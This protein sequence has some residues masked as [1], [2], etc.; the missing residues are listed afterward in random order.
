VVEYQP[1]WLTDELNKLL[2]QVGGGPYH[3]R[4]RDTILRLAEGRVIGRTDDDTWKLPETCTRKTWEGR[5]YRDA[6]GN[7]YKKPGWRDEPAVQAA[8]KAAT[9]R[10]N[11]W[12]DQA[13]ARRIA[14]RLEKLAEARDLLAEYSPLAV[15][16]LFVLMGQAGNEETRRKAAN[17][18]LD[19]ADEG[20]ATKS[21]VQETG[22]HEQRLSFNLRDFSTEFLESLLRPEG[23]SEE[24]PGEG[25]SGG[26]E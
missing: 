18:I 21:V 13:E 11:W 3:R 17:D 14:K 20:T 22:D 6:E 16:R 5:W 25:H 15:Q 10:V 4:R 24:D 9:Q 26:T 7:S 19:R 23:G 2:A 1:A 12:Q 8:L